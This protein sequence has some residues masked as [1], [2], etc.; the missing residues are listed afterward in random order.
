MNKYS[1]L[2]TLIDLTKNNAET[3]NQ[4]LQQLMRNRQEAELQ[5]STLK[6]YRQDYAVR[7]QK[8]TEIGMS[9]SNYHNFRQFIATLDQAILQ[10]NSAVAQIE[11]KLQNGRKHWYD[12]KRRLSSYE[13][14]LARQAR[15][16]LVR[17]NRNE[18]LAS[19][20]FSAKQFY[21]AGQSQ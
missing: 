15:R 7:L 9:A 5:L 4:K 20:E 12:E 10:Q 2:G 1:P 8:A 11:V 13:T 18:Q 16:E 6:S 21:R 14:L 3:A 17:D 19:D